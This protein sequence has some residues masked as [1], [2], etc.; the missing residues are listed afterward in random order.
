[1]ETF[2]ITRI[3]PDAKGDSHFQDLEI[4]MAANGEIGFLSEAQKVGNIIFRKVKPD[5]DYDFHQ[6][7]AKQY[8]IL[9]DGTIEIETSTGAKRTFLSGDVLLLEDTWGKG[10]RTKNITKQIRSSIFITL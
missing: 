5:Y 2:K 10:H 8:I 1:M 6:A 7:P 9:L 4:P 3:F